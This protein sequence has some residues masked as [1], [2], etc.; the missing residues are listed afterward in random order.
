MPVQDLEIMLLP[1]PYFHAGPES[2]KWQEECREFYM[3]M[4]EKNHGE[5]F[6]IKPASI[7]KSGSD[8]TRGSGLYYVLSAG[9]ASIGGFK[10]LYDLLKLWV[11]N[12]NQNRERVT[13]KIKIGENEINISNISRDDAIA[14]VER[15]MEKN[16]IKLT[17]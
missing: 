17:V 14:L 16:A 2:G 9:L 13:V 7:K 3:E 4:R 5:Q 8:D 1:D 6:S 10:A 15:H 12:K 11:E